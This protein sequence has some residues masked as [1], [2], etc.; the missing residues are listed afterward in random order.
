MAKRRSEIGKKGKHGREGMEISL[1]ETTKKRK[2]NYWMVVLVVVVLI[3]AIVM[4]YFFFLLEPESEEE[5]KWLSATSLANEGYPNETHNYDFTI[6]NPTSETDIY[7]PMIYGLPSDWDIS[8]PNTISL[9]STEIKDNQFTITP[10][11]ETAI[12]NTYDFLLNVTSANTQKTYSIEYQL[13]VYRLGYGIELVSYNNSHE[14]EPGRYTQY[15]IVVRNTGNGQDSV[16]L[17][18]EFLPEN[19]NIEYEFNPVIVSGYGSKAVI[20][21][22]TTHTNTS[23]GRFDVSI[24]GTSSGGPS[25]SVWLNTSTTRE[26]GTEVIGKNHRVQS[27]YIGTFT[28]AVIFDTS[29]EYVGNNPDWPKTKPI[30]HS[31][32][33]LKVAMSSEATA[34]GYTTVIVG[35][36]EGLLGMKVGETRVVRVSPGK[37][38]DDGLWRI[39]EISVVSI[40]N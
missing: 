39:F 28:D 22:I 1:Q 38:Y 31:F 29:F 9:N 11:L 10:P 26:F 15:A 16:S 24:I 33:P 30:E 21:N 17:T 19:W 37:G 34:T 25:A 8:L 3:V 7:S 35:F 12:N 13:T 23:K 40:D 2:K 18:Q 5:E 36:N 14:A 4:V 6:E 27:N 20:V 32:G